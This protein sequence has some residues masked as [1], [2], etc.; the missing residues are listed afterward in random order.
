LP[1]CNRQV[2]A[3]NDALHSKLHKALASALK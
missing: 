3:A 1:V 2:L